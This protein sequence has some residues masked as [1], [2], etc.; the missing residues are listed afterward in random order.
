MIAELSA[1]IAKQNAVIAEHNTQLKKLEMINKVNPYK[2]MTS[3]LPSFTDISSPESS[4]SKSMPRMDVRKVEQNVDFKV[5][6]KIF[7]LSIKKE[8]ELREAVNERVVLSLSDGI[9]GDET[10]VQIGLYS[11]AFIVLDRLF[12]DVRTSSPASAEISANAVGISYVRKSSTALVVYEVKRRNLVSYGTDLVR[13]CKSKI[14]NPN[15]RAVSSYSLDAIQ[16]IVGNMV[17]TNLF[18]GILTTG[19]FC[20]AA[21]LQGDGSVLISEPYRCQDEGE[22]SIVSM[23]YYVIH[24]ARET[25][26]SGKKPAPPPLRRLSETRP[27]SNPDSAAK[28]SNSDSGVSDGNPGRKSKAAKSETS[29]GKAIEAPSSFAVDICTSRFKC[30]RVAHGDLRPQNLGSDP[31]MGLVFILDLGHSVARGEADFGIQPAHH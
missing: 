25:D 26:E 24:L 4:K 3:P 31:V 10:D 30:L 23:I 7:T 8:F 19:E 13:S 18:F 27:E 17:V 11:T 9:A 16:Q 5:R 2:L 12:D 29:F 14:T 21:E 22:D 20:C 6:Q 15:T 1:V 28:V